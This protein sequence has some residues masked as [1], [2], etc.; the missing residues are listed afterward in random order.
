MKKF[1]FGSLLCAAMFIGGAARANDILETVAFYIPNRIMDALDMFSV[2]V[3][4]G[5]ITT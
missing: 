1:L 2:E 3:G 4:F 5:Y